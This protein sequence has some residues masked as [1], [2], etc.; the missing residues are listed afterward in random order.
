MQATGPPPRPCRD[1]LWRLA[2][3]TPEAIVKY[4]HDAAKAAIEDPAFG[5]AMTLRG[6]DVDYRPGNQLRTDLW[7][8]YKSHTEILRRIG[9]IKQ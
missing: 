9:M 5:A 4:V 2:S 3:G 8:E 1:R 7:R 6:I